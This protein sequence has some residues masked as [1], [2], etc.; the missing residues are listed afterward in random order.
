MPSYPLTMAE[1]LDPALRVYR[2]LI[3]PFEPDYDDLAWEPMMI[4][5][6]TAAEF[7]AAWRQQEG[8]AAWTRPRPVTHWTVR[9]DRHSQDCTYPD[10]PYVDETGIAFWDCLCGPGGVAA[11][12]HDIVY[13]R[14]TALDD[15]GGVAVTVLEHTQPDPTSTTDPDGG[16]LTDLTGLTGCAGKGGRS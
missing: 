6:V 14:R 5:H 11:D 12:D 15:S 10:P 8:A 2:V 13:L 16:A 9:F 7:E 1:A 3:E 4:G